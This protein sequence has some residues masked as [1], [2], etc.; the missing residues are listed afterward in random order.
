MSASI[1]EYNSDEEFDDD[2]DLPLPSAPPPNSRSAVAHAPQPQPSSSSSSAPAPAPS[3][4]NP[5]MD[6]LAAM[7][8]A[9][10]GDNNDPRFKPDP[11][12]QNV[13]DV[14][15]YKSWHPIYPIYLDAKRAYGSKGGRRI[16]RE[17]AH[18]WPL[19]KDIALALQQL[20]MPVF[21]EIT[22]SHPKDWAN[23]GRVKTE[24]KKDGE[25]INPK[26]TN[27]KQLYLQVSLV[28]HR[29]LS[30]SSS[31][32]SSLPRP[33]NLPPFVKPTPPTATSSS[34][35]R[36]SRPQP[37]SSLLPQPPKPLPPLS[38]RYSEYSPAIPGGSFLQVLKGER[39]RELKAKEE[40]KKAGGKEEEEVVGQIEAGDGE[41]KKVKKEK[42][43]KVK[44][45]RQG[46]R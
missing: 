14:T 43:E 42:K 26:I 36:K 30:R 4:G 34:S 16:P 18:W 29:L 44:M 32:S 37:H 27:R 25:W 12:I 33:A 38:Q 31:S 45:V 21:H 1:Q 24:F 2:T 39:E 6:S 17:Q 35:K 5:M 15:P 7:M 23:P 40:A 20:G 46:K 11:S 19:S 22:K 3:T 10:G 9:M 28:M 41:G 8:G 13:E